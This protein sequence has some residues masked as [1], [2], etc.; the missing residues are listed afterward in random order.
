MALISKIA[1]QAY[2][3]FRR[4][5][6]ASEQSFE[7]NLSK[8]L[9]LV[10]S[11]TGHDVNFDESLV[12]GSTPF[13][14]GCGLAPVTFIE[15]WKDEHFSMSIFVLKPGTRLPLHDHPGMH[16][17]IRVLH[18]HMNVFSYSLL[19]T[20]CGDS[21]GCWKDHLV[22]KGDVFMAEKMSAADGDV[23]DIYSEPVLLTPVNRNIH[24]IRTTDSAAA[25][26]DILAPPYDDHRHGH[27]QCHYYKELSV[28]KSD[29][30]LLDATQE[31][32]L[33]KIICV[34]TPAD[35]WTD[36]ASYNG[37]PIKLCDSTVTRT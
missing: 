10:S 25:F 36:Y 7:Q 14:H 11:L 29:P 8:L 35:Y 37:P 1:V 17:L 5:G 26:F 3:T 31:T 32:K 34:P 9:Q 28:S 21:S 30:K 2:N 4:G 24:E 27:H 22:K 19:E 33:C 18:G 15:L 23:V 16:G 20:K 6:C 13:V 12:R